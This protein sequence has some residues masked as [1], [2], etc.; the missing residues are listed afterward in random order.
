MPKTNFDHKLISFNSKMTS[1][2]T[3]NL[4]VLKKLNPVTTKDYSLFLDKI[5]DGSQNTFA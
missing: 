5:N 4:V 3:K 2:K 1:N